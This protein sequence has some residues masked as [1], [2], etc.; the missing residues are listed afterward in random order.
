VCVWGA[1]I[2]I[3]FECCLTRKHSV[4][5]WGASIVIWFECCLTR[6]HSVGWVSHA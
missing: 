5:V 1:S 6:K 2:V 3:W 4:C